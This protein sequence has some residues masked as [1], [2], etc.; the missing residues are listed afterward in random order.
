MNNLSKKPIQYRIRRK[1][2]VLAVK[3]FGYKIMSKVFFWIVMKKPLHLNDPQTFN[4]KIQWLKLFY[5]P[6]NDLIVQCSDKYAVR[7]YIA[8]KGFEDILVPL[9]GVWNSVDELNWDSL[10]KK[11]ALKCNHGCAYNIVCDDKQSLD[12]QAVKRQLNTWLKED[13]S[14]F[15]CEVHYS[16]VKRKI[17]CEEYIET[18]D[19]FFPIDYKFFCFNG[20]P[21]F[22]GVFIE[23]S[24]NLKRVFLNLSWEPINVTD[25]TNCEI[26]EK[27]ICYDRMLEVV[28]ILCKDF[29]FVRV[30][31]YAM[32]EKVLFGELTFTPTG[33]LA[34]FFTIEADKEIGKMLDITSVIN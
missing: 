3:L 7:K 22:V 27:P 15:N 4:E 9:L 12:F 17:L 33:G 26:P 6:T 19:G 28:K 10:P 16:K 29:I 34:P 2:Q 21:R 18:K 11:F 1:C 14:L 31:L 8:S 13:F 20:V 25:D 5:Y 32:D 23:R 24:T 30:D